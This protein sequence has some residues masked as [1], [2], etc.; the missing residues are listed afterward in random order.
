M[1][2]IRAKINIPIIMMIEKKINTI[3]L[4]FNMQSAYNIVTEESL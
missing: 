4:E 1:E 3:Y 2:L